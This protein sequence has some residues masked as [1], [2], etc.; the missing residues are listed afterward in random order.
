[1]YL[2]QKTWIETVMPE[3][4]SPR[5]EPRSDEK[6]MTEVNAKTE[7]KGIVISGWSKDIAP[8]ETHA[9]STMN[10]VRIANQKANVIDRVLFLLNLDHQEVTAKME[11]VQGFF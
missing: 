3:M 8:N 1:M 11:K 10:R 6:V 2:D 7:D 5:A 9:V 4:T